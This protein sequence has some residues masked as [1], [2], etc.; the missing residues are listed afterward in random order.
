MPLPACQKFTDRVS[1]MKEFNKRW[2]SL[3][4]PK[5]ADLMLKAESF[6]FLYLDC[7]HLLNTG[8]LKLS[9][10][11]AESHFAAW[12]VSRRK[13]RRVM[14]HV[15]RCEMQKRTV[16]ILP[17]EFATGR[18]HNGLLSQAQKKDL[19]AHCVLFAMSNRTLSISDV[20][21][22]ILRY[23]LFNQ[24][25]VSEQQLRQEGE[26][27]FST[28]YMEALPGCLVCLTLCVCV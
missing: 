26:A 11:Q 16:N 22:C 18:Y 5:Q 8:V 21:T 10:L 23:H 1:N 2:K 25:V 24:G 9:L 28:A 15:A 17:Q 3:R 4:N 12:R 13:L 20:R 27:A 6:Y 19:H 14:D 7:A